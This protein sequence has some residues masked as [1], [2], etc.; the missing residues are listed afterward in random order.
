[1][2]VVKSRG[3]I[4]N[5]VYVAKS[6][7]SFQDTE[8]ADTEYFPTLLW[9]IPAVGPSSFVSHLFLFPSL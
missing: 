4:R 5:Q 7:C 9:F 8:L 3:G 6:A 1:M 2:Q